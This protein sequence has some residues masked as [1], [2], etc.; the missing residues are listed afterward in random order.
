MTRAKKNNIFVHNHLPVLQSG[1][2]FS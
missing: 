1:Q 2:L